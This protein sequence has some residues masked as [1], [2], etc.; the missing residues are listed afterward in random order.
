MSDYNTPMTGKDCL[1][2]IRELAHSQGSYGHML[3]QIE[4]KDEE[5]L[6][7]VL[8]TFERQE[9]KDPLKSSPRLK[10]GDSCL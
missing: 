1:N 3:E 6:K 5:S 8:A 4:S 2:V 7:R 10:A 9:F